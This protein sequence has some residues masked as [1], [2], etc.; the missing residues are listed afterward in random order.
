V[1]DIAFD[2][3]APQNP[4]FIRI[5]PAKLL[6]CDRQGH[7]LQV[8]RWNQKA[9]GVLFVESVLMR[10]RA[11]QHA[12]RAS[13][14]RRRS[15]RRIEVLLQPDERIGGKRSRSGGNGGGPRGMA[16]RQ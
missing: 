6:R 13:L 2:G 8:G 9:P 4:R 16:A 11:D 3:P 12:P 7:H 14:Q 15:K 1:K 5:V 10:L